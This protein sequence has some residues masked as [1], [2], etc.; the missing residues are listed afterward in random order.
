MDNQ[1]G[2]TVSPPNPSHPREFGEEQITCICMAETLHCSET[3]TM[4]LIGYTPVKQKNFFQK[5]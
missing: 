2:P 1:Q 3:I 4:L 5:K